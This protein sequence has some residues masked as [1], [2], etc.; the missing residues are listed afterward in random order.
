M[1]R[2]KAPRQTRARHES[3]LEKQKARHRKRRGAWRQMKAIG[4]QHPIELV[5]L[6]EGSVST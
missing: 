6:A 3:N 4:A 1:A 2:Q 5:V